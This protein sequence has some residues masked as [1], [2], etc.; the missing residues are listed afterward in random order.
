MPGPGIHTPRQARCGAGRFWTASNR[1]KATR[2]NTGTNLNRAAVRPKCKGTSG[3]CYACNP[4]SPSLFFSDVSPA[5]AFCRH[6][7]FLWAAGI[8]AGCSANRPC[9]TPEVAR[10]EMAK[11]LA[12]AFHL[13]LYGP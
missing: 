4:S 12:N 1:R 8:I 3:V 7:H 11:F 10:N 5:D 2:R 9:P 13:Q 6:V